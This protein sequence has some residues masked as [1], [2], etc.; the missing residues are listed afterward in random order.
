MA[1]HTRLGR[2]LNTQGWA[3]GS[4]HKTGQGAQHTR[5]G[6][7]LNTQGWAGGSTHKAGQGAQHTR[8]GRG[9]NI[10]LYCKGDAP[11]SPYGKAPVEKPL[12]GKINHTLGKKPL[13]S[14]AQ[15]HTTSNIFFKPSKSRSLLCAQGS[16]V[17]GQGICSCIRT[18]T[19]LPFG[20]KQRIQN[21]HKK[22]LV[23]V[24]YAVHECLD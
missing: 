8:L 24:G 13:T 21:A 16:S 22:F 3:G 20:N 11:T 4:T 5:L 14:T 17:I 19:M 10:H 15:P 1:Q 23:L 2:G 7:G 6:R 12:I 18:H 9:L